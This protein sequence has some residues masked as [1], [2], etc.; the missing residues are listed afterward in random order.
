MGDAMVAGFEFE[1]FIRVVLDLAAPTCSWPLYCDG[2]IAA[3]NLKPHAAV[4]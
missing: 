3:S 4:E 2:S 1:R